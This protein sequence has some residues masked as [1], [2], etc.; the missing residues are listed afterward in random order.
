MDVSGNGTMYSFFAV[1]LQAGD[2]VKLEFSDTTSCYFGLI[3]EDMPAPFE[4]SGVVTIEIAE[5]GVYGLMT[6]TGVTLKIYTR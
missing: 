6:T 5:S 2:T 3:S 4:S 1:E